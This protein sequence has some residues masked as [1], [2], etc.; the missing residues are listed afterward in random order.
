MKSKNVLYITVP[1]LITE[2]KGIND[3]KP[4]YKL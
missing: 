1:N 3:T 2:L 4:T